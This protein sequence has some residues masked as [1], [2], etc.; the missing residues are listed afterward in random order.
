MR[1]IS[2]FLII[3]LTFT[4]AGSGQEI[5]LS[6]DTLEDKAPKEK[7]R[8]QSID[9]YDQ[10]L[11]IKLGV[12][13]FGALN[14]RYL[15]D[16]AAIEYKLTKTLSVEGTYFFPERNFSA[17]SFKVRHYLNTEE[18]ANNLSGKYVAMEYSKVTGDPLSFDS[19]LGPDQAVIFQFGNQIKKSRFGY[20]D[21]KL[22]SSY[23]FGSDNSLNMGVS[24]QV[25]ASWGPT[26][27]L[28]KPESDVESFSPKSEKRLVTL[29]SPILVLGERNI[30]FFVRGSLERELFVRGLTSRTTVGMGFSRLDVEGAFIGNYQFSI[31]Q[32]FRKYFGIL[33]SPGIDQ[34]VH[35]FAGIY[36]G[37]GFTDIIMFRKNRLRIW[38]AI[39]RAHS[40]WN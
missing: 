10:K 21:F 35:S 16:L 17:Y 25:G 28:T 19:Y 8:Y 27:P 20:A 12:S 24:V 38:R 11:L 23:H 40:E 29:E 5:M 34:P 1:N 33:K 14:D 3:Y 37:A 7:Y 2:S 30:V 9:Q 32:E 6:K 4:I 18:R 31:L 13:R 22:F 36:A 39:R 26:G 15:F